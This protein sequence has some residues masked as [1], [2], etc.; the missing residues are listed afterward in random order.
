M[1][2]SE[3]TSLLSQGGLQKPENMKLEKENFGFL[4]L[5][6]KT[7]D[8]L[9]LFFFCLVTSTYTSIHS[10]MRQGCFWV[11]LRARLS[12]QGAVS[13]PLSPLPS[14]RRS[15]QQQQPYWNAGCG[16]REGKQEQATRGRER[17]RETGR[18]ERKNTICN[19]SLLSY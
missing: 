17:G 18:Q 15:Q 5:I 19:Y 13:P 10:C 16:E 3:S 2:T 14:H 9:P 11:Y 6:L 4:L 1:H 12:S 7:I 8:Q